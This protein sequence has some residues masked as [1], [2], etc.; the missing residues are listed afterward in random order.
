MMTKE[1]FIQKLEA[2]D[3]VLSSVDA[4]KI[5]PLNLLG[6]QSEDELNDTYVGTVVVALCRDESDQTYAE[7]IRRLLSILRCGSHSYDPLASV[8]AM[9]D[10]EAVECTMVAYSR[11][12]ATRLVGGFG[13]FIEDGGVDTWANYLIERIMIFLVMHNRNIW[14]ILKLVNP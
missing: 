5:S 10:E 1:E 6:L 8:Y 4:T 7:V 12:N 11:M 3:S 14:N 9:S 13:K 2:I